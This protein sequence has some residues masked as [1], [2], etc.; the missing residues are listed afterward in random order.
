MSTHIVEV[1]DVLF[2]LTRERCRKEIESAGARVIDEKMNFRFNSVKF[3]IVLNTD[4]DTEESFLN[5]LRSLPMA[6]RCSVCK[7][8]RGTKRHKNLL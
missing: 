4:T 5:N 6:Q 8:E 2:L 3:Y 1:L 7:I